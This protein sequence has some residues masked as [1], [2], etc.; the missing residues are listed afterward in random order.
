M[1]ETAE[2]DMFT[3]KEAVEFLET[4]W[5]IKDVRKRMKSDRK[6]LV[7]EIVTQI[8]AKVPFQSIN[9]VA[10][11]VEERKQPSHE[12]IKARCTSGITLYGKK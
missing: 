2:K 6:N 7:D 4:S 3:Q 1:S 5:K 11:T 8:L 9:L 10:A 12:Q